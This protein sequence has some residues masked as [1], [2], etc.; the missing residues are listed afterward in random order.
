MVRTSLD[1]VLQMA[2]EKSLRDGLMA[3][4]RKMG[5]WRGAVTHLSLAPADFETKWPA[6]LNEVA[7]PPGMLPHWRLA[8]VAGTTETEAKVDWLNQ[9]GERRTAVLALPGSSTWARPVH[10]G[11]PGRDAPAHDRCACRRATW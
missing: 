11:K 5:G 9:A 7:R 3:Y 10:D 6:A 1:P 2:A 4:D 8:V